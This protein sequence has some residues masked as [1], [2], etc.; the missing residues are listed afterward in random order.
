MEQAIKDRLIKLISE[1]STDEE[2]LGFAVEVRDRIQRNRDTTK[3]LAN[4][5]GFSSLNGTP[6]GQS[7]VGAVREPLPA[8]PKPSPDVERKNV[9][10]GLPS[11]TKIGENA[12]INILGGLK[13]GRQPGLK[14]AE[15]CKLLWQRKLL[16]FDGT[17]YYL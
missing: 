9:S 4:T 12:K 17:S 15:H 2:L 6:T 10:P 7:G 8:T 14:Y 11:I 1:H 13:S 5:M 16:K 3:N